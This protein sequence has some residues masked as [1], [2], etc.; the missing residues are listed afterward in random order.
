MAFPRALP[1]PQVSAALSWSLWMRGGP[2]R[3]GGRPAPHLHK[4][5]VALEGSVGQYFI[6]AS[7]HLLL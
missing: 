6:N 5:T 3:T 2:P 1:Y 7:L 4:E